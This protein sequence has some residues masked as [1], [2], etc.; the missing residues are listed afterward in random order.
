MP[1]LLLQ[2]VERFY[3][4]HPVGRIFILKLFEFIRY[5]L[6]Y[7]NLPGDIYGLILK[8]KMAPTSISFKSIKLYVLTV[9]PLYYVES[10]LCGKDSL[11]YR[12]FD[13]ILDPTGRGGMEL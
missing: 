3:G 7:K 13:L 1:P 2:Y 6:Y 10:L 4:Y 9:S 5:V 8:N 11:F 12:A